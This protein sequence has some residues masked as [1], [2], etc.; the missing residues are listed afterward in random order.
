MTP[1]HTKSIV[2]HNL[3]LAAIDAEQAVEDAKSYAESNTEVKI[4]VP[5]LPQFQRELR[6]AAKKLEKDG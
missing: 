5:S 1:R 4:E 2:A 6:E 3:R